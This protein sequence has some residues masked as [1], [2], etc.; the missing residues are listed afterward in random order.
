MVTGSTS[1]TQ[2][3]VGSDG[4][5]MK[6]MMMMMISQGTRVWALIRGDDA[7]S[8]VLQCLNF[9]FSEVR[10]VS[11]LRSVKLSST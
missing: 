8:E 9:L 7:T 2:R 5:E 4:Y 3:I 6:K 1:S 10:E 11:G